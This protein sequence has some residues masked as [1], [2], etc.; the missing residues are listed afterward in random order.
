MVLTDQEVKKLAGKEKRYLVNDDRGLCVE[1]HPNGSKYWVMRYFTKGKAHRRNLGVYPQ[2]SLREA[3][4]MR[5]EL[6]V[7]IA[8]GEDI[9]RPTPSG[10]TFEDVAREWF[11]RQLSV[12][13]S[14][15]YYKKIETRFRKYILPALGKLK[16]SEISAHTIL[17]LLRPV[18]NA[19][20]IETAHRIKNTVSQIF[21]YAI[22]SQRID[23]DPTLAIRGFLVNQRPEHHAAIINPDEIAGLMRAIE[24][25]NG[26]LAVKHALLLSAYLFPR[27]GELRQM[28]WSEIQSS[29][30]EWIIPASKM[31][32]KR[33]HIVPLVPRTLEII[34]IMRT[35]TGNAKYVFPSIRNNSRPMSDATI[36]AALR[37]M[38]YGNDQMTAHGFRAMAST[39]LNANGWNSDVIERQL[40]HM[41]KNSVRAAYNHADFL[42]ERRKMMEWWADWLDEKR[43]IT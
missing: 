6:K 12:L 39:M 14:A 18:E 17:T 21:R 22:A 30:N 23:G 3:R 36:T 32:M 5:D 24:T 40:A 31:K 38:G 26:S 25:I 2:V 33:P 10:E 28:E 41:D 27:P 9:N 1:V 35:F 34:E 29:T 13:E 15:N 20:K 11:T 7:R 42:P 4:E 43:G 37:R 8:K 16:L 19:G